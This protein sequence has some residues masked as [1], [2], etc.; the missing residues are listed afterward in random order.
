MLQH[1]PHSALMRRPE[2]TGE[3][4]VQRAFEFACAFFRIS[5]KS[6]RASTLITASEPPFSSCFHSLVSMS[7][8]YASRLCD[9][10]H[11]ASV[12]REPFC[13]ILWLMS[14]L[15]GRLTVPIAISWSPKDWLHNILLTFQKR[16]CFSLSSSPGTLTRSLLVFNFHHC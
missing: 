13:R 5:T 12:L 9:E 15:V 2:I 8:I 11:E 16:V 4:G 10:Q 7:T 1:I 6:L 3:S 14:R